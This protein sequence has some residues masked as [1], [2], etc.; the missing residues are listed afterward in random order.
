MLAFG[1]SRKFFETT[2]ST[3][4]IPEMKSAVCEQRMSGVYRLPRDES[5]VK[6]LKEKLDGSLKRAKVLDHSESDTDGQPTKGVYVFESGGKLHRVPSDEQII[7]LVQRQLSD[8]SFLGFNSDR[9][10]IDSQEVW[11]DDNYQLTDD[12]DDYDSYDPQSRKRAK[13]Q[14]R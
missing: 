13:K 6:F 8:S 4:P 7:D 3:Q 2:E 14:I 11:L 10:S 12:E 5:V 9:Y 1:P